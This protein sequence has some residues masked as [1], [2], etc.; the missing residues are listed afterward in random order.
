MEKGLT[1]FTQNVIAKVTDKGAYQGSY[2]SYILVGAVLK[3]LDLLEI[4]DCYASDF[5]GNK[6][7]L[8]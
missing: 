2:F 1:F 7:T 6:I 8:Q 3:T 5:R 4:G